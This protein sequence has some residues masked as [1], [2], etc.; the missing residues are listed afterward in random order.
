M[1]KSTQTT[2]IRTILLAPLFL[3]LTAMQLHAQPDYEEPQEL[4]NEPSIR[5]LEER[6]FC[7]SQEVENLKCAQNSLYD[8]RQ[9]ETQ[10]DYQNGDYGHGNESSPIARNSHILGDFYVPQ[11][12]CCF[13][14][15]VVG[16][17]GEIRLDVASMDRTPQHGNIIQP[18]NFQIPLNKQK[19]HRHA[20]TYIDSRASSIAV[21]VTHKIWD[22]DVFGLVEIDFLSDRE[23]DLWYSFDATLSYAFVRFDFPKKWYL[24][25]GYT[26]DLLTCTDIAFPVD[27][28]ICD[29]YGPAGMTYAQIPQIKLGGYKKLGNDMGEIDYF[30]GV[31]QQLMWRGLYNNPEIALRPHKGE[32]FVLPLFAAGISWE[33]WEP[34][35]IDV[36]FGISQNR[37]A[38]KGSR[39]LPET[40]GWLGK[41][42]IQSQ[43]FGPTVYAAY[44]YMDGMDRFAFLAF[45][46]AILTDDDEIRNVKGHGAFAGAWFDVTCGVKCNVMFG[47][48]WAKPI[49]CSPFSGD[50]YNQYRS[51]QVCFWR[52]FW[53]N[54][55]VAVEYKRWEVKAI[56]GSEGEINL[57]MGR[58]S[59]FF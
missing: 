12:S 58:F 8:D 1:E 18:V 52:E 4:M 46:D 31:E 49:H 38:V 21:D 19:E 20:V 6:I 34:L 35:Q 55:I 44:S 43:I 30:I 45:P 33:K 50:I 17:H 14:S 39:K 28:P 32:P 15:P 2:W 11:R 41:V 22:I 37:Y 23:V 3:S 40:T 47:W 13:K 29:L 10:G 51:G 5:D 16:V 26:R 42:S 54:Y 7:L 53:C 24:Q 56:N 48:A 59:F 36:R 57:F 25:L 27:L 9:N